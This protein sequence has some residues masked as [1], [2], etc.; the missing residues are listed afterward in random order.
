MTAPV[1]PVSS[2]AMPPAERVLW[3]VRVIPGDGTPA[4]ERMAV[5]VRDERIAW[6]E[7]AGG[8]DPPAEAL[9]P[10]LMLSQLEPMRRAE[11]ARAAKRWALERHSACRSCKKGGR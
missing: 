3:N 4:R 11:H 7:P 9:A 6:V 5:G 1:A 8:E 10:M 2:T